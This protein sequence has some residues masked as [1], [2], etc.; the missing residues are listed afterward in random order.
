MV[1]SLDVSGHAPVL[2]AVGDQADS[3]GK[4][5]AVTDGRPCSS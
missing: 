5:S 1:R 4:G 3:A 2:I